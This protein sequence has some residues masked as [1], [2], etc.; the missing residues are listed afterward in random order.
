MRYSARYGTRPAT[1]AWMHATSTLGHAYKRHGA[2]SL[3][4]GIDLPTGQV[5]A[6]IK[7]CHRSHGFIGFLSKLDT[8][9]LADIA[10][11]VILD[12]RSAHIPKKTKA[13]RLCM[14]QEFR[15]AASTAARAAPRT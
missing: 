9:Y 1:A 10:I 12:N 14:Q 8:A 2:L 6:R 7:D 15:H 3:L 4:A 13:S 5:H 11:K